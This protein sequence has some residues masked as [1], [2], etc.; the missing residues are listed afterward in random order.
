MARLNLRDFFFNQNIFLWGEFQLI[1]FQMQ[2]RKNELIQL[3]LELQD[4]FVSTLL[5]RNL[6]LSMINI[7]YY[8]IDIILFNKKAR[9]SLHTMFTVKNSILGTDSIYGTKGC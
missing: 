8:Q 4:N 1:L 5:S 7:L 6:S 2:V 9:Y 3:S